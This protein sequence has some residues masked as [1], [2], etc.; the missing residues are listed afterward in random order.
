MIDVISAEQVRTALPWHTAVEALR[1]GFAAGSTVTVPQ[2]HHHGM[3]DGDDAPTLLLMPAWSASYAGVKI[4]A[5]FPTNR[6]TDIPTINGNYLL[7]DGATGVPLAVIDGG[8]LTARRTAAASVLAATMLARPHSSQLLVVGA[9]RLAGNLARAYAACFP[10][11]GVAVWNHRRDGAEQLVADLMADGIPAFVATDL[12][13]A[14]ESADIV[15]AATLSS[16][17]VVHGAWLRPG[18]HLD[19]VGGFTPTMRETDDD[20][21]RL[22]E[23][24]V[25][26]ME[27][28]VAEAGD[29]VQPVRSG[30][31]GLDDIRGDLFA[32]C[33]ASAPPA[34]GDD[35]VTLFKSVGHAL[36]DLV[37]AATVYEAMSP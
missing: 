28:A 37:A 25:D 20:A 26:T 2:R 36:E 33:A 31:L 15:T 3:G 19:L 17:P 11:D 10:L 8:E 21:V 4:V 16:D 6:G 29:I 9:G 13:A 7:M 27:G 1:S 23:V 24:Y 35:A 30:V 34:R 5:V 12:R 14:V 22:A 32:L 18:T